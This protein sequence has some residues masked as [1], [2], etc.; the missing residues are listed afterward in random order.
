MLLRW[1]LAAFHLLAL[2]IGLGAVAARSRALRAPME[3]SRLRS[4]FLADSLWGLAGFL[5]IATG[6]WRAFGGVEKGTA[7][8]LASTAFWIKMGLLAVLLILE[9]VAVGTLMRWRREHAQGRVPNLEAA[10]LLARISA[11]QVVIVVAMVFAA[12]AM[13]RGIGS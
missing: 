4:A 10:P 13:A 7:Y 5:W 11:V 8:Y 6:L 1:W 2:G 12:T 3:E 9:I